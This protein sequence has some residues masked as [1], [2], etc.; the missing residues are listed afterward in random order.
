MHRVLLHP[1]NLV[2]DTTRMPKGL[3]RFRVS[4]FILKLR[5]VH[6]LGGRAAKVRAF[7]EKRGA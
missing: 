7:S 4:G 6:T 3:I 1:P 5:D 2:A